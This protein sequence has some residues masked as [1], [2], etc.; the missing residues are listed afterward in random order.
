MTHDDIIKTFQS[1]KKY[2]EWKYTDIARET[3]LHEN[4]I[5]RFFKGENVNFY[6]VL[7]IADALGL[8][9]EL[10]DVDE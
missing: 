3:G 8:K 5:Q 4:S 1:K 9:I 2:L 7:D 10:E 6:R